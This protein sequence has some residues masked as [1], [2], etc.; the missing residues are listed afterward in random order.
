[1]IKRNRLFGNQ[2]RVTFCLPRDTPPGT[3]SVVGCFNDWQPGRHELVARRDGTRTVTVRLGPGEY[4]FR[5]LATGG[6]WLD[7]ESAD[8]VDDRG[9]TL[10]L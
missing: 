7:D 2:T 6:V 4:R 10:R 9:G 3:V 5:Y 1:M 8:H